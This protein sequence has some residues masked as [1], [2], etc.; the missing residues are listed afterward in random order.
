MERTEIFS[1]LKELIADL[2]NVSEAE[3]SERSYLSDLGAESIDIVNMVM[4]I[5][6]RFGLDEIEDE[7]VQELQTVGEVVDYLE[8]ML[9]ASK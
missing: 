2:L 5:E 1:I 3:I 7:D 6:E 4:R 8:I 9:R